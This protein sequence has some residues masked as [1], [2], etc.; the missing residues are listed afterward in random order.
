[1]DLVKRKITLKWVKSK[2]IISLEF[3]ITLLSIT[4]MPHNL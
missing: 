4:K 2:E 1:M 3:I